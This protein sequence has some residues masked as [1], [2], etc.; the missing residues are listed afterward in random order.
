MD[1]EQEQFNRDYA[2]AQRQIAEGRRQQAKQREEFNKTFDNLVGFAAGAWVLRALAVLV[3]LGFL[4][5]IAS[6]KPERI[7]I[8][9]PSYYPHPANNPPKKNAS[10]NKQTRNQQKQNNSPKPQNAEVTTADQ[11][12]PAQIQEGDAPAKKRRRRKKKKKAI[13]PEMTE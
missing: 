6:R 8:R 11:N 13:C 7:I 3:G 2:A 12:L 9:E 10:N 4:G 1:K 5:K